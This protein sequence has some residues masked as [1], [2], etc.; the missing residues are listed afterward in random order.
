VQAAVFT[1]CITQ[2]PAA[3]SVVVRVE[4]DV[5]EQQALSDRVGPAV[6][7]VLDA[8]RLADDVAVGV[9]SLMRAPNSIA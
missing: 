1:G 4:V 7:A 3:L 8:D 6:G 5:V 9:E 2:P